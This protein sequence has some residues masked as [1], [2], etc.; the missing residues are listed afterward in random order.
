MILAVSIENSEIV[1][2]CFNEKELLFKECFS[3]DLLRTD[4][5]Y[6][7]QIKTLLEL[8]K[9]KLD[10][11]EGV[12]ISSVV[13]PMYEKIKKSVQKLIKAPIK[14]VGPG[15]KTG[16]NILMD[17]PAQIGSDMIT[18]AVGALK[19]FQPPIVV[20]NLG[21]ATT[22]SVIDEKG[23]YTGGM[24]MP[25]VQISME[26]L[27]KNTSQ[28]Q[29]IS[30]SSPKKLIGKNTVQCM[31]SGIITGHAASIDGLID[32]IKKE[33]PNEYSLVATGSFVN[34]IIPH[35]EN[36]IKIDETLL[37]RGLKVIFDKNR[38]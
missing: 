23:N 37:L 10:D 21:T 7:M 17:N 14:T 11:I 4:F 38:R 35:C 26:A 36:N 29:K 9:I 18:M 5:E 1:I 32:R 20:I 33:K 24:I 34:W 8:Y 25:G 30:M 19:S 3:T 22:L 13:P 12:I 15:M 27:V 31:E 6:A 2:G 16:I 28:L